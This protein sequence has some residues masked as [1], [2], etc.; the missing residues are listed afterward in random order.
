MK[1]V[2]SLVDAASLT[3]KGD[4]VFDHPVKIVEDAVV[5]AAP[6]AKV[7]IPASITRIEATEVELR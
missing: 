4:V 2:P 3:V 7:S 6:G 1:I 5:T